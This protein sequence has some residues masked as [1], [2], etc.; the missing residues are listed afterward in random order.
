LG[1]H[2]SA[3]RDAQE[4]LRLAPGQSVAN[5]NVAM[6]LL[7]LDQRKEAKQTVQR[8]LA[9][10]LDASY[11]HILLYQVAFLENDTKEMEAQ[12]ARLSGGADFEQSS[13]EAYFGRIQNSRE[14]CKH[15]MAPVRRGD[16]SELDGQLFDE[17]AI[18]EAEF[19]NFDLARQAASR[20]LT[21]SSGRQAKL[22]AAL[23][24]A[25][26][27]E[28]ARAQA[29]ADEL[30]RKLPSDT[31]LQR[32]WLPTIRASI[33][34]ARKNPLQALESLRTISYEFA[35][36]GHPAG[37]LYPVYVRGQAYLGTFQGKEA[38]A[39][40]QK[41]I[42][43]LGIVLNGRIGALAHLQLGRAYA[44]QGDNTRALAAYQDFLTLW[45]DAD[46]DIPILIAAKSEY[47]KFH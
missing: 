9:R 7:S 39:E 19:G 43:H 24:L 10:G 4:A 47:L 45:K 23:A 41:I 37:N 30:N 40:F 33:E 36:V 26:A 14:F 16:S 2:K 46:H 32:Y 35:M 34:L 1:D 31:L 29:L 5:I 44:L 13:T 25:S 42:D 8:A 17:I 22:F 27:G 21:I 28:V 3:L 15:G 6:S 18:R 20:A 12:V 11:M 38:A